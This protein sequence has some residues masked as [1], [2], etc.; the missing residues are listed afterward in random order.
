MRIFN[1]LRAF[2]IVVCMCSIFGLFFLYLPRKENCI[3]TMNTT[4]GFDRV[5][6]LCVGSSHM[7]RGINPLQ[8]Y[9]DKGFASYIIWGGS[10]SPWQSYY[11]LK[12]SLDKQKPVMVILDAYMIGAADQTYYKDYQTVI[13]LLDTPIS[14]DKLQAVLASEAE[15]KTDILLRFPYLHDSYDKVFGLTW[16]KYYGNT[17]Y[18]M[19]GLY[20]NGLFLYTDVED[21]TDVTGETV[22][23]P[24]N[25]EYLR[26]IIEFCHSRDIEL[27]ISNAPSPTINSE[28]QKRFNYIGKIAKEY[29]VPFIDGNRICK[30][31]GIDWT[32]DCLDRSGH[33]NCGG[34]SKYTAYVEDYISE[35]YTVPDRRGNDEY[36]TYD[37]GVKRLYEE[38]NIQDN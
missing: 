4:V 25:E 34:I 10:Q 29:D 21:V 1:Y 7:S 6:V 19:G 20:E 17:D 36:L 3:K 37:E 13:N 18:L 28:I 22:I 2:R 38:N 16:E 23:S 11:F 24:K 14:V 30:E 12:K 26:K 27:I 9:R 31:I 8:M 35:N 32:N 15:S 5:D 33:L